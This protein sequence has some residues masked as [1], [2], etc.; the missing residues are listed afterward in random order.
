MRNRVSK[1]IV[2]FSCRAYLTMTT[3]R[4]GK[5]WCC[6]ISPTVKSSC[7]VSWLTNDE[8]FPRKTEE[9]HK[10]CVFGLQL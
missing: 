6:W 8:D 5:S 4:I 2:R 3:C 7:S 10:P 9:L 1:Q